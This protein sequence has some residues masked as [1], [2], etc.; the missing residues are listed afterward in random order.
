MLAAV[1]HRHRTLRTPSLTLA[2]SGS[3]DEA[4]GGKQAAV[5]KGIVRGC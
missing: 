4:G 1:V 5:A 2:D 3:G